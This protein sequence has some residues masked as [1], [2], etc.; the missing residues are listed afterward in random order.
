LAPVEL[1]GCEGAVQVSGKVGLAVIPWEPNL[2]TCT[3]V[4]VMRVW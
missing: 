4:L 1:S 3:V 2:Y